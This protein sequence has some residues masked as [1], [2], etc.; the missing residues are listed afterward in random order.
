MQRSPSSRR[1]RRL[2][3]AWLTGGLLVASTLVVLPAAGGAATTSLV[4]APGLAPIAPPPHSVAVGAVPS[5]QR[6]S[7]D[8]VLPP[9]TRRR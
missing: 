6:I 8:V 4:R 3:V 5:A 1:W 2:G 9:P 7:L